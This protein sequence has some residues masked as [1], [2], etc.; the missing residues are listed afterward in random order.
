MTSDDQ[1]LLM[2][3]LGMTGTDVDPDSIRERLFARAAEDHPQLAVLARALSMRQAAQVPDDD[4]PEV[5]HD[6]GV[7]HQ[8]HVHR[9]NEEVCRLRERD[10]VIADA[11]GACAHCW[12]TEPACRRCGGDGAPGAFLPE[13]QLFN[14]L[15][16]PA[17]RRL[18]RWTAGRRPSGPPVQMGGESD[19]RPISNRRNGT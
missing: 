14:E 2:Q 17:I 10:R 6:D 13:A 3:I 1:A 7:D 11:L 18:K 16:M 5:P 4:V 12:G 8:A 19:R 15:V 9:L